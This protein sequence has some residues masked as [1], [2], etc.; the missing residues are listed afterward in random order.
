MQIYSLFYMYLS[1]YKTFMKSSTG[2]VQGSL[3]QVFPIEIVFPCDVA[4]DGSALH[5]LHPVDLNQW[6]LMEQQGSI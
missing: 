6:Q 5:Q 2:T 3:L 4:E 1:Y